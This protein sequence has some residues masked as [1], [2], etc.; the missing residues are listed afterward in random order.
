MKHIAQYLHTAL[1]YIRHPRGVKCLDC[2]FLCNAE[3][4]ELNQG[5]RN[6]LSAA[7][8]IEPFIQSPSPQ[9]HQRKI[10]IGTLAV[11]LRPSTYTTY[12]LDHMDAM[13]GCPDPAR[14]WCLRR[15]WID[16][17]IGYSQLDTGIALHATQRERRGCEGFLRYRPGLSPEQHKE[18][19]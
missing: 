16:A 15:L 13:P 18:L 3:D 4:G 17:E 8:M 10:A 11:S 7:R 14:L 5:N 19:V 1:S 2:G 9:R 12:Q 6:M